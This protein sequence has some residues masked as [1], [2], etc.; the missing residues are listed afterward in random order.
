MSAGIRDWSTLTEIEISD[1]EARAILKKVGGEALEV[2]I[3]DFRQGLQV[4]LE[5]G[6]RFPD[7]NI[8]NNHPILTGQIVLAHLKES[9]LYYKRI[10]VAEL[11]GDLLK[12]AKARDADKIRSLYERIVLA[13]LALNQAEAD[14]LK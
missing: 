2:G 11:E 7:A 8:T 12:A 1:D 5:H 3:E 6:T 14:F 9:L 13:R 4:E 10:A